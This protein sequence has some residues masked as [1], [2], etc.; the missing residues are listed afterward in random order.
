MNNRNV[1]SPSFRAPLE[2]GGLNR[3]SAMVSSDE[4]VAVASELF[5]RGMRL[6][7]VSGHDDGVA[8]RVVYL[9]T[10]GPPDARIEIEVPLCLLYT[11]P[12]PRDRT[13]SRMP[14][15]A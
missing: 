5:A 9:F 4:L 15:S 7:L 10:S 2:P 1:P 11:S 3:S 6:A 14:S 13:R 12:S 8:M